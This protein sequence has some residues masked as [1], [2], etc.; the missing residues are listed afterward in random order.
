[1]SLHQSVSKLTKPG[2]IVL[3][4]KGAGSSSHF[5]DADY[6]AAGAKVVD[7]EEVWKK[8]DIVMKVGKH[9]VT[10]FTAQQATTSHILYSIGCIPYIISYVPRQRKR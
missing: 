6:E 1:M 4:E 8:S 9:G 3:I 2:F 10:F 5:S 7:A